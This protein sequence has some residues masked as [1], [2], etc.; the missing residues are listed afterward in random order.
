[1]KYN[2]KNGKFTIMSNYINLTE[3]LVICIRVEI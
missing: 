3:I 1:M 2:T